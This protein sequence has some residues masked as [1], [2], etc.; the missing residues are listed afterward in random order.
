MVSARGG[1]VGVAT[2][3]ERRDEDGADVELEEVRHWRWQW[4]RVEVCGS[5]K[6]TGVLWE[7]L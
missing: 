6:E 1:G 7:F 5:K 3:G 2:G 4:W